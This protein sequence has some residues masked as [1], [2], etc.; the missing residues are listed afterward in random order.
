[1]GSVVSEMEKHTHTH[2]HTHTH[3]NM[4]ILTNHTSHQRDENTIHSYL[5]YILINTHGN[6]KLLN[7][8]V[9]S[10]VF[11]TKHAKCIYFI[12]FILF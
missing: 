12:F 5:P 11:T 8:Y 3:L 9:Q 6:V 10:N 1:M 4:L 7:V 2:T